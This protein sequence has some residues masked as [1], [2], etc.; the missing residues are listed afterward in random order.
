MLD[1]VFASDPAIDR[2]IAEPEGI[3]EPLGLR[4]RQAPLTALRQAYQL[5][6]EHEARG[7][8]LC[9]S[10]ISPLRASP[11][12]VIALR[13]LVLEAAADGCDTIWVTTDPTAPRDVQRM[14]GE[15]AG[16][17]FAT[18][19]N[20]WTATIRS[21]TVE[22]WAIATPADAERAVATESPAALHRRL[23]IGCESEHGRTARQTIPPAVL[24]RPDTLAIWATATAGKLPTGVFRLP[25]LQARARNLPPDEGCHGL[26]LYQPPTDTN[27][28]AVQ[29]TEASR[30]LASWQALP[31]AAVIWR[32]VCIES[33]EGDHA[34]LAESLWRALEP[35]AQQ[36]LPPATAAPL[37]LIDCQVSCGTSVERRIEVGAAAEA[38]LRLLRERCRTATGD[39][40]CEA[41]AA[42]ADESLAPLGHSR[43][44]GRP[45]ASNSFTS[46]LADIVTEREAT[47]QGVPLDREAAWLALELLAA[48]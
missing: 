14:L 32:T 28:A 22:L 19:L 35:L 24:S 20:P 48:D 17:S 34:Q 7:V 1:L 45:G 26:R 29:T 21:T 47:G 33:A 42:D 27:E 8:V 36:P 3:S 10:V 15:P 30:Q 13:Q 6:R 43:S 39:L 18:P 4:L 41:V 40:W 16:L 46:A 2:P 38:T 12:Q 5:A 44:G 25:P 11:A 31:A 9:G 37:I 23:L